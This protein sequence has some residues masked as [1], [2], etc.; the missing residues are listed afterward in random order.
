MP[1]IR[2]FSQDINIYTLR[3][4]FLTILSMEVST[5]VFSRLIMHV[6]RSNISELLFSL[7]SRIWLLKLY[8]YIQIAY[9]CT[10]RCFIQ[11]CSHLLTLSFMQ[12]SIVFVRCCFLCQSM[13]NLRNT[14]LWLG[15]CCNSSDLRKYF[16]KI[17][18]CKSKQA[19]QMRTRK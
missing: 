6:V 4:T 1:E 13:I 2:L 8:C 5:F 11:K 12:F 18:L 16:F 19:L 15:L 10:F 17:F 7:L 14:G 3:L 9:Y